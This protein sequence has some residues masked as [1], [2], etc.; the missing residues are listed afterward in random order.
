MKITNQILKTF[1]Q[2]TIAHRIHYARIGYVDMDK[3]F[4]SVYEKCKHYTM[5]SVERMYALYQAV[6]YVVNK[7]IEGDFVECGVWKGGSAMLMAATLDQYCNEN[8]ISMLLNRIDYTGRVA[9]K[10]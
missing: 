9:I 5:T 10:F 4:F 3:D 1:K 2:K 6:K 7:N 8:H